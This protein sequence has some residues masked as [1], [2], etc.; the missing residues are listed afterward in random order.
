VLDDGGREIVR[1]EVTEIANGQ[2]RY[3]Y[4]YLLI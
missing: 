4:G 1:K 3:Y 2:L